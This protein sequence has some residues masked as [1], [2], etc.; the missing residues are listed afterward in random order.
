MQRTC[1]V[2]K[3]GSETDIKAGQLTQINIINIKNIKNNNS[4]NKT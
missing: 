2:S 3:T 1:Y 4:N